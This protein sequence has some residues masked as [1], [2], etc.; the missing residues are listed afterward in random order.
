[1]QRHDIPVAGTGETENALEDAHSSGLVQPANVGLGFVELLNPVGRH[2]VAF[3]G[4]RSRSSSLRPISERTSSMGMPLPPRWANQALP[5][6]KRRW[7]SAVTGS[8]SAGALT[9]ARE[10]GFQQHELKQA[11]DGGN[12]LW[13][14]A[15]DQFVR[16][17][18]LDRAGHP[19]S[20][21]FK[22]GFKQ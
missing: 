13:P 18:F 22:A 7:S 21:P 2:Y 20:A 19:R 4:K 6:R 12:L 11:D 17:L 16:L 5:S 1:M 14:Q 15:L 9:I 3:S 10:T 8:S